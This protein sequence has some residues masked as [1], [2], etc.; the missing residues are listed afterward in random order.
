MPKT[1]IEDRWKIF[2][3][4]L[5]YYGKIVTPA[6]L[7]KTSAFLSDIERIHPLI[8]GIYKPRWSEHA[9][10]IASMKVNPYADKLTYLADGRWTIQYSAKTG[11][12][13]IAANVSLFNCMKDKEPVIVLAQLSGKASKRGARYRLMGLGL[14]G[15]YDAENEIFAIQHVDFATLER[16]SN[17]ATDEVFIASALQAFTLEEFNPFVAE[18]KAIYQIASSK[19]EKA[20]T[21]VVLEQY[22]FKCAVTGVKYHSDNLIEAHAAHI[23]SKSQKGSDDPRNG[24]T[25]SRMA[26]WAFDVGMFTISDQ[27]EVEVHPK[28]KQAS[29]NRFPILDMNGTRINLPEDENYYPHQEALQWHRKEVFGRF[30]V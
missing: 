2:R 10:S 24:I 30:T 3:A 17:G 13:R 26:H 1:D 9:L 16:I 5:P 6:F 28:A 21:G 7:R 12:P 8:E 18:D 25:L 11:G 22:D 27:L 19:R 29:T 20:F 23:V 4:L 14:I 15:G